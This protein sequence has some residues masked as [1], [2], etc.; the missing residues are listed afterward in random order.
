MP[1]SWHSVKILFGLFREGIPGPIKNISDVEQCLE[2]ITQKTKSFNSGT[3]GRESN[4]SSLEKD[5]KEKKLGVI[6]RHVTL[7][8]LPGMAGQSVSRESTS[9]CQRPRKLS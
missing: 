8:K 9:F 1:C 3:L 4:N 5:N 6:T 2:F 7:G